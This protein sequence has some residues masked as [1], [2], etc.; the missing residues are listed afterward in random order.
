MQMNTRA[1]VTLSILIKVSS[2]PERSSKPSHRSTS[3]LPKFTGPYPYSSEDMFL[4]F[5]FIIILFNISLY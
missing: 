5:K 4:T 3:V 2:K 1:K